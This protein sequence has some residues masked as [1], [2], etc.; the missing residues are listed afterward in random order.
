MEGGR[1]DGR[2]Q[3]GRMTSGRR[4]RSS[5]YVVER[6]GLII[7]GLAQK[8]NVFYSRA[9]LGTT[10]HKNLDTSILNAWLLLHSH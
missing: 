2:R 8:N 3:R 1:A 4:M 6:H 10:L 9:N 5:G 7:G